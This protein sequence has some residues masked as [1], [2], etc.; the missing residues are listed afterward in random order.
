MTEM[1]ASGLG[2]RQA[3][4][5][6]VGDQMGTEDSATSNIQYRYGDRSAIHNIQNDELRRLSTREDYFLRTLIPRVPTIWTTLREPFS[7]LNRRRMIFLAIVCILYFA[8][9]VLCASGTT[10]DG[11]VLC[12]GG[13]IIGQGLD[14]DLD[15]D[16]FRPAALT[17]LASLLLAFYSSISIDLYQDAYYA[18]KELQRAVVDLIALTA[19]SMGR[20]GP[21]AQEVIYD[22][23]RCANI[24]HL[25]S[26]VLAD[27]ARWNYSFHGFVVGVGQ[28][29]GACDGDRRLGMF[30][31]G[32]LDQLEMAGHDRGPESRSKR[33]S[34]TRLP[35]QDRRDAL[36]HYNQDHQDALASVPAVADTVTAESPEPSLAAMVHP[37]SLRKISSF[38]KLTDGPHKPLKEG[39]ATSFRTLGDM[40]G[41]VHSTPALAMNFYSLR[42]YRVI[43]EALERKMSSVA[44]PVWGTAISN[45]RTASH[46]VEERGLYRLPILYRHSVGIVIHLTI[47]YDVFVLGTVVGRLFHED[48]AYAWVSTLFA[49]VTMV[50]LVVVMTLV[51]GASEDMERPL[52]SKPLSLPGLSNVSGTAEV[53]LNM[54][55]PA[56]APSHRAR[57][58]GEAR[59]FIVGKE[60]IEALFS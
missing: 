1:Q 9:C 51:M 43:Q 52:G 39:W 34:Q 22:V 16:S 25:C 47:I 4:D 44:W 38:R 12:S 56:N 6:V 32:E 5:V 8:T 11:H 50:V 21:H 13:P 36:S 57:S 30:L 40:R 27:K 19:G 58:V 37:Q 42:L 15:W 31:K 17:T 48:Y 33:I 45:L 29:F 2:R 28:N 60:S 55:T 24:V 54:V 35:P 7:V 53:T 18:T 46:K 14:S 49:T 59:E 23:W 3:L 41:N 26:Y 10:E 20:E